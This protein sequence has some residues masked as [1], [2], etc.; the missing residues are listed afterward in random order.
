MSSDGEETGAAASDT[1]GSAA[2]RPDGAETTDGLDEDALDEIW[3]EHHSAL[4]PDNRDPEIAA[5]AA[6]V[7]PDELQDQ[8]PDGI[9]PVQLLNAM[10]I[11]S[12]I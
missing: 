9:S 6:T 2:G 5:L 12:Q 7:V 3:T 8:L 4:D 1:A 10:V 11:A